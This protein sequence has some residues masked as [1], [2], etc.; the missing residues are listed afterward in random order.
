MPLWSRLCVNDLPVWDT[1]RLP[2][3]RHEQTAA[4]RGGCPLPHLYTDWCYWA[5]WPSRMDGLNPRGSQRRSFCHSGCRTM[6]AWHK[7]AQ[8]V[9][10]MY[11][12]YTLSSPLLND[13]WLLVWL[14]GQR[15]WDEPSRCSVAFPGQVL[16]WSWVL[17]RSRPHSSADWTTG[18][19]SSPEHVCQ[20][21]PR[22][23]S[24]LALFQRN[25][26]SED[27]TMEGTTLGRAVSPGNKGAELCFT[28]ITCVS[29]SRV[30]SFSLVSLLILDSISLEL[31][32]EA[33]HLLS[34]AVR[35]NQPLQAL[36]IIWKLQHNFSISFKL[37]VC[38]IGLV[39]LRADLT[40]TGSV[41]GVSWYQNTFHWSMC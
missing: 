23:A 41:V 1:S 5:P 4:P 16:H 22:T 40:Q 12:H 18:R 26:A 24:R 38:K 30:N 11:T 7:T 32:W 39:D 25:L 6:T 29:G 10:E 28:I 20:T 9:E 3:A 34:H 33:R 27:S 8:P 21:S 2:R 15:E 14:L 17:P 37:H 19:C 13:Y 36:S 31:W 35:V